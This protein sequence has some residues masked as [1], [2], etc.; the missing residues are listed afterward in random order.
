M[1]LSGDDCYVSRRSSLVARARAPG[2]HADT[3]AVAINLVVVES[4][5]SRPCRPDYLCGGEQARRHRAAFNRGHGLL[6]C[7]VELKVALVLSKRPAQTLSREIDINAKSRR[8]QIRNHDSSKTCGYRRLMLHKGSESR[9]RRS[10]HCAITSW[11]ASRWN[12]QC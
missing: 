8:S 6:R 4:D 2:P 1:A 11:R 10:L 5:G 9:S 3:Y 12:D 7:C